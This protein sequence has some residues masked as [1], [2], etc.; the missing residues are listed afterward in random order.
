MPSNRHQWEEA[1]P[2][3]TPGTIRPIAGQHR[4]KTRPTAD[5]TPQVA[6]NHRAAM[7]VGRATQRKRRGRVVSRTDQRVQEES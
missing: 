4:R 7:G 3:Q 5:I 1:G 6:A 2:T